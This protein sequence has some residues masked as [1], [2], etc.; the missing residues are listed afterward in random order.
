MSPNCVDYQAM[1]GTYAIYLTKSF[2]RSIVSSYQYAL[3]ASLCIR[4][5]PPRLPCTPVAMLLLSLNHT[6]G[7][8][9]CELALGSFS[10]PPDHVNDYLG[11]GRADSLDPYEADSMREGL[12]SHPLCSLFYMCPSWTW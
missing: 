7:D 1:Y 12:I 9:H 10:E 5:P 11:F 8:G 4:K 2:S 6:M 3:S